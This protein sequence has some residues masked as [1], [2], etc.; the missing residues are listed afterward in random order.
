MR[1]NYNITHEDRVRLFHSLC[2]LCKD[3]FDEVD[4]IGTQLSLCNCLELMGELGYEAE[5]Q[6]TNGWEGETWWICKQ[7]GYPS[8]SF[9]ASAYAG[10][11]YVYWTGRDDDED[12]DTEK[13]K[14]L[15]RK[16]WGKYFPVI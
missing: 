10:D 2:E 7:E 9:W 12:I 8:I 6:D 1:G 15:M 16:H 5:F 14:E 4:L 11:L 3:S 13:L